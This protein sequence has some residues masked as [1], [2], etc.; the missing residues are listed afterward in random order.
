MS[1]YALCQSQTWSKAS[2]ETVK[3]LT[4]DKARR[5]AAKKLDQA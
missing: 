2:D 3:L 4:K 1:N 5:I